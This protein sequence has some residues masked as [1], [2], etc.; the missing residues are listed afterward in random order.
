MK[1]LSKLIEEALQ[2]AGI[3]NIS[4]IRP[5]NCGYFALGLETVFSAKLGW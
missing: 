5:K 3:V 1:K 4:C 2:G